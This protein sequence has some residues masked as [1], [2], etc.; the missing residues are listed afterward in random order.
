MPTKNFTIKV[1]K[2]KFPKGMTKAQAKKSAKAVRETAK[3][4]GFK[5]KVRVVK[6]KKR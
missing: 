1:D 4:F 2:K 5:P 6:F 3:F